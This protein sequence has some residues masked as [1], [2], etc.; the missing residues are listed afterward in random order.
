[1]TDSDPTDPVVPSPT[2][3][4]DVE[5]KEGIRLFAERLG[6]TEDEVVAMMDDPAAI[7]VL[8][9][10]AE[11]EWDALTEKSL[12]AD[13][14]GLTGL[15]QETRADVREGRARLAHADP[16]LP[17][18]LLEPFAC[19]TMT[20]E[21]AE[22]TFRGLTTKLFR[23]WGVLLCVD[24]D[25]GSWTA[26]GEHHWV[27]SLR[28]RAGPVPPNPDFEVIWCPDGTGE[29]IGVNMSAAGISAHEDFGMKWVVK[30]WPSEWDGSP[31]VSP[32]V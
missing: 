9:A 2:D 29:R 30:G 3:R 24:K 4:E 18:P 16:V 28:A 14:S 25:L 20:R 21:D 26:L 7:P 6:V 1:M 11:D 10:A 5:L 32:V 12:E 31:V 22:G 27:V 23:P 8:A 15:A 17:L 13:A 19:A